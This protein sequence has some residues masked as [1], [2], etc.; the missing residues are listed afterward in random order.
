[1]KM[2]KMFALLLALVVCVGLVACGAK[3]K[4]AS[5]TNEQEDVTLSLW[6]YEDGDAVT[7]LYEEFCRLYDYFGRENDTMNNIKLYK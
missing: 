3:E 2:K 5:L 7:A 6:V 1:M 4:T